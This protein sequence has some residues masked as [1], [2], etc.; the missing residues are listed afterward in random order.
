MDHAIDALRTDHQQMVA[1]AFAVRH[2]PGWNYPAEPADASA[3][4]SE[5]RRAQTLGVLDAF[6]NFSYSDV[7]GALKR[8]SLIRAAEYVRKRDRA[9]WEGVTTARAEAL[10][11]EPADEP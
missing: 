6:A 11:G 5:T 3:A 2:G 4:M 9:Y 1:V 10:A 8:D 7:G